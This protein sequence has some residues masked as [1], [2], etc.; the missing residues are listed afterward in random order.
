[1]K[2]RLTFIATAILIAISACMIL[3]DLA[4]A[5]ARGKLYLITKRLPMK[6][7]SKRAM[8]G[9]ARRHHKKMIWPD[10]KVKGEKQ[11]KFDFMVFF[12]GKY[13]DVE[14]KVKFYDITNAKRFIMG[15]SY[16]LNRGM[17]VF[18]SK[19]ILERH[20]ESFQPNRR[21]VMYVVTPNGKRTLAQAKFWLRGKGE[22]YSGK[23]EFSDE[24][25]KRK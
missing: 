4:E 22:V 16:Y 25:A 7:K 1:M 19:M 5:R 14:V 24:E 12:G 17:D 18:S 2:G 6:F 8:K 9:W 20:E 10:K 15:D 13:N 11:W 23:V 3:P 21:Y